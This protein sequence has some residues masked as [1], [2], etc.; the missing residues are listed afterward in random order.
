MHYQETKYGFEFGNAKI[1]RICSDDK[2]GWV[3]L[4]IETDKYKGDKSLQ[5]YITKTGKIRIYSQ[6]GEWLLMEGK[7]NANNNPK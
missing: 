3:L 6:N 5:V 1:T 7:S 4:G 2:R